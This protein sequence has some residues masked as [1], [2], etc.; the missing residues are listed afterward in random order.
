MK[1]NKL[2][3][4]S[5]YD[6]LPHYGD[7]VIVLGPRGGLSCGYYRG[8]LTGKPDKWDWRLNTI[9]TVKY[10]MPREAMPPMPPVRK[11]KR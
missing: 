10:W 1:G 8:C 11:V 3:W 5:V 2:E 7:E 9:K 6:D 4:I